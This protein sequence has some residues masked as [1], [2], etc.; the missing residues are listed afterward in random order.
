MRVLA[1]ERGRVGKGGSSGV[2][3]TAVGLG[4]RAGEERMADITLAVWREFLTGL[5]VKIQA[6]LA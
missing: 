4:E 3:A 2:G 1:M 6:G 5:S